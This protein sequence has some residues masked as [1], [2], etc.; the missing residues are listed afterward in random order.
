MGTPTIKT[1]GNGTINA[2][3]RVWVDSTPTRFAMVL[4]DDG[5]SR[6]AVRISPHLTA[7]G[8][9]CFQVGDKVK[10]TV[11]TGPAGEFPR[12][13]DLAKSTGDTTTL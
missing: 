4:A 6:L 7:D 9:D 1:K 5:H 11:L 3:M 2:I 12:V 13:Q 8:R 10:Y